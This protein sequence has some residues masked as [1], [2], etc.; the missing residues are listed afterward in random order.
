MG[1][2]SVK[3]VS[4]SCDDVH[5]LDRIG[6]QAEEGEFICIVGK[7]GC[8]KTTLLRLIAGLIEPDSGKITKCNTGLVFQEHACFP[9]LTVERNIEFGLKNRQKAKHYLKM[10]HLD[11]FEKFYPYQLSSGMRQRVA[12]ARTLITDPEVVL[13][14]E[15]FGSLDAQTKESMHE[16]LIDIWEREKKTILFVTHDIDEALYLADRII[17]MSELPSSI[18]KI[19]S[20][21]AQG[22]RTF[23]GKEKLRNMIKR[24]LS[25]AYGA[26]V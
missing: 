4:K 17:I 25:D 6:F 2:L 13:M 3:G 16:F 1:K 5:V 7:S 10:M 9:W 15:P 22:I 18:T 20:N 12:I 23:S 11:G 19:I 14:D 8:G 24:C 26:G 21:T